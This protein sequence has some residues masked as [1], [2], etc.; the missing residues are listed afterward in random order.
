MLFPCMSLSART[1]LMEEFPESSRSVVE[2]ALETCSYDEGKARQLL[3]TFNSTKSSTSTAAAT[4][5]TATP[6]DSRVSITVTSVTAS[7][8]VSAADTS[9]SSG[10]T[11]LAST[12][13]DATGTVSSRPR[14]A[15]AAGH[16]GS[17]NSLHLS[18]FTVIISLSK[19]SSF[20]S[21]WQPSQQ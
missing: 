12:M 15:A 7:S 13:Y 11:T 8:S 16:A 17:C 21:A 5:T 19:M 18:V 14:A 10:I 20:C 2:L 6:V 4:T 1:K 3:A 9:V